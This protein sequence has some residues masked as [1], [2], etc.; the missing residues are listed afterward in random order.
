MNLLEYCRER[1]AGLILLSS[2]RV[3]S[4]RDLAGLPMREEANAFKLD[5]A[6]PLP[7]GVTPEGID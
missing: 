4:V 6:G 5:P 1:G 7:H 3:Y 2:S